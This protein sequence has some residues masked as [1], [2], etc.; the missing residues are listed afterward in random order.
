M[1]KILPRRPPGAPG[2]FSGGQII[3]SVGP[4]GISRPNSTQPSPATSGAEAGPSDSE[5]REQ[6]KMMKATDAKMLEDRHRSMEK[7]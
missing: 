3:F 2:P 4:N 6:A 1:G 7:K 5:L